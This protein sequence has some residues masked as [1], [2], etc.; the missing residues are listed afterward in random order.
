MDIA[1]GSSGSNAV[2]RRFRFRNYDCRTPLEP[3]CL[4]RDKSSS[5]AARSS[6]N[7]PQGSPGLVE[8]SG[9][10]VLGSRNLVKVCSIARRDQIVAV[11]S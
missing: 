2:Y 5:R 9:V 10:T 8:N 6:K 7:I 11:L 4:A 1:R 3:W